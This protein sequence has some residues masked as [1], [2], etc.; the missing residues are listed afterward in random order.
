MNTPLLRTLSQAE[1]WAASQQIKSPMFQWNGQS[2]TVISEDV[3]AAQARAS[4]TASQKAL[5]EARAAGRIPPDRPSPRLSSDE[6]AF[7]WQ[8]YEPDPYSGRGYED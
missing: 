6:I 3:W 1:R 5:A 8:H 7:G 4:Y 2:Y